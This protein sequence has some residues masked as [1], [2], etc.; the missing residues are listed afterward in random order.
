MWG[1]FAAAVIVQTAFIF[2]PGYLL[3]R[4]FGVRPIMSL[5]IAPVASTALYFAWVEVLAVAGIPC[6]WMTAALPVLAIAAIA[7]IIGRFACKTKNPFPIEDGLAGRGAWLTLALYVVV[8]VL[9]G[10]FV[11]VQPFGDPTNFVQEIDNKSH[12]YYLREFSETGIWS[13]FAGSFYPRGWHVLGSLTASALHL[14]F[15]LVENALDFAFAAIVS[16]CALMAFIAV[17]T[18][19]SRKVLLYGAF[20]ASAFT[21]FP[22]GLI[23][24]GPLMPNMAAYCVFPALAVLFMEWLDAFGA[25]R[26]RATCTV[27]LLVAALGCAALHPNSLF[28]AIVLFTPFCAQ[29]IYGLGGEGRSRALRLAGSIAFIVLVAALWVGMFNLPFLHDTVS[30]VWGEAGGFKEAAFDVLMLSAPGRGLQIVLGALVIIGALW[31]LTQKR[32]RWIPFSYAILGVFFVIDFATVGF[33]KQLLTGFWYSDKFR[34]LACMAI[35][36]VPLAAFGVA[37]L[38]GLVRKVSA[39]LDERRAGGKVLTGIIVVVCVLAIYAPQ[40]AFKGDFEAS[41]LDAFGTMRQALHAN[42]E[43]DAIVYNDEERQFVQRVVDEIGDA[44]VFNAADDG[45]L[46]AYGADGLN[47]Y[48]WSPSCMVTEYPD[49]EPY[50]EKDSFIIRGGLDRISEDGDVRAAVERTGVEYVVLLDVGDALQAQPRLL[51][52]Y[53]EKGY[54]GIESIGDSTPGFQVVLSDGDMRL[55]RIAAA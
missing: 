27:L 48:F 14:D 8:G 37:F 44:Q 21:A 26:G 34:I 36:A 42:T 55:Y 51:S 24:F 53:T 43:G 32:Y 9:V 50:E 35:T 31:A 22:W 29:R 40:N 33:V 25:K 3:V 52:G 15:A 10:V 20:L 46:F 49:Y 54:P 2:V 23:H 6:S 47:T 41:S 17:L 1:L 4:A 12:L 5:L 13:S 18:R 45:S 38:D 30:H 39:G 7:F 16:P 19:G 28:F 11:L